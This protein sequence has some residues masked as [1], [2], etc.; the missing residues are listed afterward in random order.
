MR[1]PTSEPPPR[2]AARRHSGDGGA[3]ALELT[4]LAPALMLLTLLGVQF[5]LWMYARH[6]A[7]AS[8]QAGA[9]AEAAYASQPT[10]GEEA[11]RRYAD[12]L[13]GKLLSRVEVTTRRTA[14]DVHIEVRGD[15]VR[16]IPLVP[17]PVAEAANRTRERLP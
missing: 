1:S 2:A 3:T 4:L 5:A 13:G 16:I 8:A 15:A 17:L 12:A 10:A 14:T 7:L 9:R 6:V 11:A